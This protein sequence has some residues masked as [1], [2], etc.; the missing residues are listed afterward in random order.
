MSKSLGNTINIQEF[1]KDWHCEV[2]RF[3]FLQNHYASNVD[4]SEDVFNNCR[5]R[6]FYFYKTLLMMDKPSIEENSGFPT[7]AEEK[8]LAAMDTEF[9]EA[10]CD[11]F[12]SPKALATFSNSSRWANQLSSK[13]GS[14]RLLKK[15]AQF[16][17]EK[18]KIFGLLQEDPTEFIKLHK[19][20][21]L[22]DLGLTESD[23]LRFI[24]ERQSARD[25]KN[26]GE[27]D[28]IRASLAEKGISLQDSSEGTTWT[29]A[30]T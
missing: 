6:L 10:I 16:Q 1:L 18:G 8:Q 4:F 28:R 27:S 2:L 11:D 19:T 14:S 21:I 24:Q 30:M 3:A 13:K 12:N 20:K 17:R 5:K 23:L 26:W 9:N 22:S 25:S 15:I 29:L 7:E